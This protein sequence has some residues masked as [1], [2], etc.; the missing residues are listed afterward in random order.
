MSENAT[1]TVAELNDATDASLKAR[2][3]GAATP[4]ATTPARKPNR[5]SRATANATGKGAGKG[6]TPAKA[7]KPAAKAAPAAK[8]S[9]PRKALTPAE[10]AAKPVT[11]NIAAYVEWLNRTVFDGKMTAAMIRAAGV[12]ITLYGAYQGSPERKALR[13]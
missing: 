3:A 2:A 6:T 10:R 13:G 12:S 4:T 8:T 7:G 11:A 1:A 5:T 9:T